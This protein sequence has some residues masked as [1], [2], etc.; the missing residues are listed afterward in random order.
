MNKATTYNLPS[1]VVIGCRL[2][3]LAIPSWSCLPGIICVRILNR[4]TRCTVL[5]PLPLNFCHIPNGIP[6]AEQTYHFPY[7]AIFNPIVKRLQ[8]QPSCQ[9][10]PRK[11]VSILDEASIR[12]RAIW[13]TRPPSAAVT[14][15]RRVRSRDCRPFSLSVS[16]V[17]Y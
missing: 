4:L 16:E 9:S 10:I 7:S 6:L 2:V 1:V 8:H 13:S 17:T 12:T 5:T 14:R 11:M 3:L 15:G